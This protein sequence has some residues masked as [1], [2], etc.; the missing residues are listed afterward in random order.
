M[1]KVEESNSW[2]ALRC[3]SEWMWLP[4]GNICMEEYSLRLGF[5]QKW[6][7][8]L[9]L[10]FTCQS[11]FYQHWFL[12]SLY[13]IVD[14]DLVTCIWGSGGKCWIFILL[15]VGSLSPPTVQSRGLTSWWCLERTG[16]HLGSHAAW[17]KSKER[18]GCSCARTQS[19]MTMFQSVCLHHTTPAIVCWK[20]TGHLSQ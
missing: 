13:H 3:C 7:I 11:F 15:S 2:N 1:F 8:K 10:S 12:I 4:E 9:A 18:P 6:V 19:N 5:G 14:V 17:A 16:F 20:R